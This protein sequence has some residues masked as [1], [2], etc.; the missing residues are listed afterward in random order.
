M[1]ARGASHCRICLIGN[2]YLGAVRRAYESLP[3]RDKYTI[4]F[5]AGA[6]SAFD[7]LGITENTIVNA[8][9][10][11]GGSDDV[12][13]YDCFVIYGDAPTP[14]NCIQFTNSIPSTRYSTSVRLSALDGWMSQFKTIKLVY[15]LREMTD[16]PIFLL[17]RN[18]NQSEDIGTPAENK[19]GIAVM[20]SIIRPCKF[21]QFP[22]TLFLSNRRPNPKYYQGSLNV[23]GEEPDRLKQPRHHHYHLNADGGALILSAIMT[24]LGEIHHLD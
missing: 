21:I 1:T 10:H 18:V 6:G 7:K 5:F 19:D 23:S 13:E 16:K 22:E 24:S 15:L 11:S 4:S 8:S 9:H 2:S 12:R 20:E 14:R 3:N 17:S